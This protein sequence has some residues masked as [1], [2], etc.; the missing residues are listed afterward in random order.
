VS[1]PDWLDD[2]FAA[3]MLVVAGY[4]AARLV[5]AR[6]S[7]RPSHPDVDVAHVLMGVAMAGMLTASLNPVPTGFW[8][9]V[10][11]GLGIWFVWRCVEFVRVHGVEG[12]DEDHV[13][14]LSHYLTHLVMVGAMLYMYAVAIPGV[15]PSGGAGMA[16]SGA[17]GTTADFVG[18]P[19]LFVTVLLAS[20]I[21]ELDGFG[22]LSQIGAGAV[23]R[24][25]S[26]GAPAPE[27]AAPSGGD[28]RVSTAVTTA[29]V[30][31]GPGSETRPW[32]AP[33][34]EAACHIAMCITMS[35]MLVLIL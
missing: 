21:W 15:G 33:R 12:R 23:A 31:T 8:E 10:F 7:A 35:Y 19:L 18:L 20:A 27:E 1:G 4:S 17:T 16:M 13:H 9:L 22:R 30:E 11:G 34:L 24:L 6:R 2:S 26:G 29:P 14:H 25:G 5:V 32:L 28:G 3:V